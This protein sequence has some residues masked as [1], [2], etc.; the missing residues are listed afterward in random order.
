MLSMCLC[1]KAWLAAFLAAGI[2]LHA[3]ASAPARLWHGGNGDSSPASSP[4]DSPEGREEVVR[5]CEAAL[6]RTISGGGTTASRRDMTM[7]WP[8]DHRVMSP[9]RPRAL[10]LCDACITRPR[11]HDLTVS[12]AG[13]ES[14]LQCGGPGLLVFNLFALEGFHVAEALRVPCAA[15]SPC[16]VP[17]AP[18]AGYER[19]FRTAHPRLYRRL[20]HGAPGGPPS[21]WIKML[22]LPTVILCRS[23]VVRLSHDACHLQSDVRCTLCGQG[24]YCQNQPQ[25]EA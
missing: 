2:Q 23:R 21:C 1:A 22:L 4:L 15:V 10:D 17:S 3:L 13:V 9:Q 8:V 6:G 19:R 20:Q 24:Q 12:S 5:A 25:T 14:G 11:T 16:L 7:C 18:P